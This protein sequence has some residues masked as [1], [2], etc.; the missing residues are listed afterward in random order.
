MNNAKVYIFSLWGQDDLRSGTYITA[1]VYSVDILLVLIVFLDTV[2]VNRLLLFTKNF[3]TVSNWQFSCLLSVRSGVLLVC[4][5]R[6]QGCFCH[7]LQLILYEL[8]ELEV[9]AKNMAKDVTDIQ[10]FITVV[11]QF[12]DTICI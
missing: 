8:L 5:V 11:L 10:T 7:L 12:H 4:D 3:N 9:I 6:C 1:A 2:H